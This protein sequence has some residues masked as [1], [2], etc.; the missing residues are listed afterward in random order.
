M[1][2][3]LFFTS[4]QFAELHHLNKRTLHYYDDIGLFSPAHRGTNGY[5]Y[6]T[7]QQSMEL[8]NILSLRELGMSIEEIKGYLKHPNA[9]DFSK[10][11]A[12][13]CAEINDQI[14]HLKALKKLLLEKQNALSL[15]KDSFDGKIEIIK[16]DEMYLLLTPFQPKDAALDDMS[17]I[18]THLKTS[19][20]YSAYKIGCGNYISIEKV[21]R[22]EF[23]FYDGLFTPL[24]D[25]QKHESI[26]ARPA[27]NYLSGTNIGDWEKIPKLY[28][29]MLNFAKANS[30]T[31]FGNCYEIGLNEFAIS[32]MD[33]Y[34]TRIEIPC[35]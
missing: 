21:R 16:H 2:Q 27:G 19:W 22:G 9:T 32:D 17:Q 6:Y 33:E 5:R 26:Y 20:D 11:V 14:K 34:V 35:R 31:L 25:V 30:L 13:K 3:E 18:M 29:R 7:Y 28:M 1:K 10:I 12:V 23:D 4:G 24:N 15:C 8:E